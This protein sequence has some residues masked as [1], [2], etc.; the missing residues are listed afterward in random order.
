VYCSTWQYITWRQ[1]IIIGE[2]DSALTVSTRT[3]LRALYI[4]THTHT[5]THTHTYIYI[6]FETRS[7]S[8]TQAGVQ[9]YDLGP[10]QPSLP[11]FKEFLCLSL[12]SSW[13]YRHIPPCPA[14]FHILVETRFHHVAQ[15]GL[16]LLTSGD[17]PALASQSTGITGVSHRVWPELYKY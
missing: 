15:A 6:F 9:W 3:V 17:L 11:R 2:A 8:V 12:K 13:G 4:C 1:V 16:E 5:H 10:L 7:C 14:N